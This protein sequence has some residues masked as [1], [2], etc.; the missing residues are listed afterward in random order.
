M[1]TKLAQSVLVCVLITQ[2]NAPAHAEVTRPYVRAVPDQTTWERYSRVHRADRFGK[3]IIDIKSD[4]IYFIDVNIFKLHADFVLDHLLGLPW[5]S[6]NIREYNRN[7][8]RDKPRFILGYLTHHL[9]VDAWTFAFWAGD[10]IDA[11]GIARVRAHLDKTFFVKKLLF[12]PDSPA[13]LAVA[14]EVERLGIPT[15]T[16]DRIY[17]SAR[18]QSFNNGRAVGRLRVVEPGTP[19]ESLVFG[20]DEIVLLQEIYPDISPVAGILS[21][22]FS[23]PLAHVNLR[24][25]SWGIPNAGY[26]DAFEEYK[27]LDG[28][29]VYLEVR[30]ATHM[31]RL[32]SDTEI[33]ELRHVARPAITL[34]SADLGNANMPMLTHIAARDVNAFGAKTANLGEIASARLPEVDVPPGFGLPFFYYQR[35]MREHGLDKR[36]D[37]LLA[38][39]RFAAD[40]VW[41]K[42]ALEGMQRAI[43]EAPIDPTVLAAI[44][45]RVRIKLDGRGAF[46]RSSTNAEDLEGF[47]GAGLYDTVPNV[48]GKRALGDAIKQVWASLWNFRAVEERSLFGIDHQ[49]VYAGVLIQVGVDATAAGVLITTNLYDHEDRESFTINAKRGLGIRVVAGT[50]VPEQI[51]FDLVNNGTR[52]IS[53]SDDPTMLVF[54]EQGGIRE[55]ANEH[56]GVILTEERAKRLSDVIRRFRP[57]FPADYPLDVEWLFEGERVWIVQSRP[58]VQHAAR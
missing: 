35:H 45:K 19:Y 23:T 49:Q 46:V 16:N 29:T 15:I 18:Y 28:K 48:R 24:A 1:R 4:D 41:R 7:Y 52:I 20:R 54:D 34:P 5:T 44:Y 39:P 43:R 37:T 40:V 33:S 42:Q 58:Y 10:K 31:L 55:V 50:R 25:T 9:D 13:Q 38:D 30:D 56:Q 27:S 21:T 2:S 11:R 26:V 8:E 12:R 3:F 32:A 57:L 22:V 36:L 53:R 51:V 14:K 17:K 47:N 6:D